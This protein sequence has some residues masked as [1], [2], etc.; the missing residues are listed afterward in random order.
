MFRHQLEDLGRAAVAVLDGF[1]AGED[2]AAHAFRRAGVDRDRHAGALGGLDR[3][4]HFVERKGGMRAGQRAPAV[5]A[6]ELDPVGAVAD[7]V[8]HYAGQAVDAVGLF[9]ALRHAPFE[10]E[11]LGSVAAGGDDGARGGEHARAGNDALLDRLLQFD[12]G[13]ARAFG[14]QVADGGEAGHQRARADD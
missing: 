5:I 4:L 9:R 7:L 14:A 6:V 10:R 3:E 12:I 13:V 1:G 2:G 8:A 11:A